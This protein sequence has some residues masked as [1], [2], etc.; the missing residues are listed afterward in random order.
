MRRAQSLSR[1]PVEGG[2]KRALALTDSV[3]EGRWGPW[4]KVQVAL[5]L[6]LRGTRV[7]RVLRVSSRGSWVQ[8]G[9]D[10]ESL[11]WKVLEVLLELVLGLER[12]KSWLRGFWLEAQ[13]SFLELL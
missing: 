13:W 3:C 8:R 9:S 6:L 2:V 7:Q 11:V 1:P 4:E 12:W 10:G 5:G